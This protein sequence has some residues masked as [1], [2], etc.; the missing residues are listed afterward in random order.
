MQTPA[1]SSVYRLSAQEQPGAA[2][3]YRQILPKET[4]G[5]KSPAA[6][7]ESTPYAGTNRPFQ[8]QNVS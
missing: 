8:V 3:I 7:L 2:G 6:L 4:Q 5:G 1:E